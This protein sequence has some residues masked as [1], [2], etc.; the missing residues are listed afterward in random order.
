M[1]P[2]YR[3][4][5]LPLALARTCTAL[6]TAHAEYDSADPEL[7]AVVIDS[8]PKESFLGLQLDSAGRL[9]V[10]CR[11]ALFVY[12][13]DPNGLYQPRKLLY[14]FPANSWIYAIAIRGNDLYLTTH[15][16]VYR[17]QAA[18]NPPN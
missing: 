9:F 6:S 7:K 4:V 14:R 17:L 18:V 13:P 15:T 8:D 2:K 12:E 1:N 5:I 16:A 11:E 3:S 10:G